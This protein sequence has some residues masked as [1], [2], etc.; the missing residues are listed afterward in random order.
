[1]LKI[2]IIILIFYRIVQY[3]YIYRK[4][5]NIY[6]KFSIYGEFLFFGWFAI[7]IRYISIS[8]VSDMAKMRHNYNESVLFLRYTVKTNPGPNN[9]S[10]PI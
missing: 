4:N 7:I 2:S 8:E 10:K 1:M 3:I 6:A 9:K 5:I